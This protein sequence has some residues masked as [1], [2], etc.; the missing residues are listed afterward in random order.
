MFA[1]ACFITSTTSRTFSRPPFS[2]CATGRRYCMVSIGGWLAR[3]RRSSAG[4]RGAVRPFP[5]APAR[6]L[7][8]HVATRRE[9]SGLIVAEAG[10]PEE[11]HPFTDPLEEME[12]TEL[13][14][15]VRD[16]LLRLP[17]KYRSPVVLCYF[18]GRTHAEAVRSSD[19]RPA[20]S[21]GDSNAPC[22]PAAATHSS[23]AHVHNRFPAD[24]ARALRHL[25]EWRPTARHRRVRAIVT[26]SLEPRHA[27]ETEMRMQGADR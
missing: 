1:G 12:R 9:S 25:Q 13:G 7:A 16:E 23:R 18:E 5:A 19:I 27:G 4:T 2:S 24:G 6:D 3:C 14:R 26:S 11:L 20:L 22:P 15:L 8:L 21:P 17:E 10:L